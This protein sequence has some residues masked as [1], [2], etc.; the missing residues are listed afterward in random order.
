MDEEEETDG[1]LKIG[2]GED[3]ALDGDLP[4][5]DLDFGN[6]DDPENSFH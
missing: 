2:G 6:D 3:E 5:E 1:D 4:P